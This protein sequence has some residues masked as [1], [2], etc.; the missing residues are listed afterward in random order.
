MK[1]LRPIHDDFRYYLDLKDKYLI[2]LYS[3]LREYIL[4][5]HP[6]CTELIYHTHALTSVYSLSEKLSDAFCMIPI[7][8]KH[9]NLGFNK[10]TLL[11]DPKQLLNGTGK[12]IRHIPILNASD[13]RNKDALTL[14]NKAI[15]YAKDDMNTIPKSKALTISKIKK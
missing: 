15:S 3:D 14:I 8:N 13:Y 1:L 7:Y 12:Y 6:D 10:G 5:I 9:L 4:E 11:N 2:K